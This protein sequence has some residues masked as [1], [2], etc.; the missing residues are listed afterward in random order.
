PD[1]Q[2]PTSEEIAYLIVNIKVRNSESVSSL[3]NLSTSY[4]ITN[5]YLN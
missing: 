3:H 5:D 1:V 2:E 4:F